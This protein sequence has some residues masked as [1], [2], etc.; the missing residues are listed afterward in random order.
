[1]F[2]DNKLDK[3][4]DASA[5][6]EKNEKS[7]THELISIASSSLNHLSLSRDQSHATAY[8]QHHPLERKNDFDKFQALVFKEKHNEAT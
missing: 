1:M 4:V 8:F 2:T 7:E 6:D 3:I 5:Y